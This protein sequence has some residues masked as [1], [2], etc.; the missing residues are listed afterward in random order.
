M[1]MLNCFIALVLVFILIIVPIIML[2][3]A[4]SDI[5]YKKECEMRGGVVISGRNFRACT[6]KDAIINVEN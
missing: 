6:Q 1:N 4:H 2:E 5:A 3:S